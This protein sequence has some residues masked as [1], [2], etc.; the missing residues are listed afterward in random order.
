MG[1]KTHALQTGKTEL[2][3][4]LTLPLVRQYLVGFGCFFKLLLRLFVARVPIGVELDGKSPISLLDFVLGSAFFNAEDIVVISFS[5]TFKALP[6]F[7]RLFI[8]RIFIVNNFVVRIF[9]SFT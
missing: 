1:L 4:G 9:H 6:Y 3:V 2:V 8:F 5:Q 7:V